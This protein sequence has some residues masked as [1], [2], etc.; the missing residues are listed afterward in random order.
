MRVDVAVRVRQ[1]A[2]SRNVGAWLQRAA[3]TPAESVAA[4]CHLAQRDQQISLV[5][6]RQASLQATQPAVW[7]ATAVGNCMNEHAVRLFGVDDRERKVRH[8]ST[9]C[10]ACRWLAVLRVCRGPLSGGLNLRPEPCAEALFDGFVVRS[11]SQ[12]LRSGLLGKAR[13]LQGA[14]RRASA[15][16]SSAA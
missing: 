10:T 6:F 11:L 16:T 4:I 12:K 3:C 1:A 9:A 14:I 15:N 5:A 2:P 13:L 8:K 7:K